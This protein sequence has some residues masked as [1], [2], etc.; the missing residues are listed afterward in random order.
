[1]KVQIDLDKCMLSGECYYNHPELFRMGEGGQ[2]EV[3]V[4]ELND[5]ELLRHA[6]EAAQ[7]CPAVAIALDP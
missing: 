4:N 2:P 3:L 6:R 1:M 5:A 7:V